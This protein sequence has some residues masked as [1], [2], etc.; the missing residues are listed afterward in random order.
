MQLRD[1]R[2]YNL[3]QQK[4]HYAKQKRKNTFSFVVCIHKAFYNVTIKRSRPERSNFVKKAEN[5]VTVQ[6]LN[7]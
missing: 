4:N 2:K 3:M 7:I 1:N 6:S 5:N